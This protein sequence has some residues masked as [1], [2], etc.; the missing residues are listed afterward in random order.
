MIATVA[1][2]M[3]PLQTSACAR[4]K[5]GRSGPRGPEAMMIDPSQ[6][7][8]PPSPVPHLSVESLGR[9]QRADDRRHHRRIRPGPDPHART[10]NVQLDR[11]RARHIPIVCSV[12]R[13]TAAVFAVSTIAGTN[14]G[15]SILASALRRA[16]RRRRTTAAASGHDDARRGRLERLPRSLGEIAAFSRALQLRRRPAPVKSRPAA[17]EPLPPR[18]ADALKLTCAAASFGPTIAA[19]PAPEKV[20]PKQRLLLT[21]MLTLASDGLGMLPGASGSQVLKISQAGDP[22]G[23]WR[24][25]RIE[26]LQTA[27]DRAGGDARNPRDRR[28][29]A[30]PRRPG[31]R[32]GKKPSLPFI[33]LRQYRQIALPQWHSNSIAHARRVK[34]AVAGVPGLP[35]EIVKRSDPSARFGAPLGGQAVFLANHQ[36]LEPVLAFW[37]ADIH[38]LQV[39]RPVFAGNFLLKKDLAHGNVAR[40]QEIDVHL[41]RIKTRGEIAA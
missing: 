27:P 16:S 15:A 30:M 9:L 35:V 24:R 26:L 10:F 4:R 3:T 37:R 5:A 1:F 31:L 23:R 36:V 28:Y 38:Y 17:R 6:P 20:M 41:G 21:G 13:A 22:I 40:K 32:R 12:K 14:G 11:V 25:R 33:Q 34:D 18:R 29:A 19:T 8:S 7:S 2:G 39:S